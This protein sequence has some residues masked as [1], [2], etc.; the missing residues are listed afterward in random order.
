ME[1][2]KEAAAETKTERKR[3]LW[4]KCERCVVE[5]ELLE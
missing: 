1:Q 2:T 4:L 5:L 3:A